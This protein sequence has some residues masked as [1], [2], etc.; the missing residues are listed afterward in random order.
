MTRRTVLF[1]CTGNS[2]RSQMAEGLVNHF[3]ENSWQAF[4]AGTSPT[5]VNPDS[6][7][8][9]QEL[10]I[11]ISTHRSQYVDEF[12]NTDID[13]VITVCGNADQSCPVWI[14][15]GVKTHIPFDDPAETSGSDEEVLAVFRRVRDEIR[16]KVVPFLENL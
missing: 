9:M 14:G 6:I 7:R 4:S 13:H 1:L 16:E 5:A 3:L 8:V 15:A 10:D 12:R 2:C 11:D